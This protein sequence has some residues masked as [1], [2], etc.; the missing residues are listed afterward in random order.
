V[1][2]FSQ[3][4]SH[5]NTKNYK[6]LIVYNSNCRS[7]SCFIPT[8]LPLLSKHSKA[9]VIYAL[10]K[11]M[12]VSNI[13]F[14]Y[15]TNL[16]DK[17]FCSMILFVVAYNALYQEIK[18]TH[19]QL[20]GNSSYDRNTTFSECKGGKMRIKYYSKDMTKRIFSYLSQQFYTIS[21]NGTHNL[22]RTN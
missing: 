20:F 8:P 11:T 6:L 9:K 18:I 5:N 14:L 12:C 2:L 7:K 13:V 4:I 17:L 16:M 19:L 21:S 1:L 15:A 3:N 22:S 10:Q